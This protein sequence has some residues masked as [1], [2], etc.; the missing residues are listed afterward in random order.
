MEEKT[1]RS[2]IKALYI[3]YNGVLEPL[4]HSQGIPYLK[5]LVTNGIKFTLLSFEKKKHMRR[6]KRI[7]EINSELSR[8]NIDWQRLRYH[9]WPS[10]FA[11]LWD[12]ILGI[13]KS[14]YLILR[15]KIIIVHARGTIPAAIG[16]V[17]AKIFRI[18][19]IFDMRGLLAEEYVDGGNWCRRGH[20]YYLVNALEKKFLFY[21]DAIVVLTDRIKEEIQKSSFISW[22]EVPNIKVIPCCVDLNKFICA[23]KKSE[24]VEKFRLK[25]K[26]VFLYIGSLGTWYLL[27]EMVDFFKTAMEIIPHAHFLIITHS[28]KDIVMKVI[29]SKD[30]N[31][32]AFSITEV[33]PREMADF[34]TLGDVGVIFIKSAFSKLAS[35][36][37]KLGEFLACGLP[38][39]IN[40]GIGDTEELVRQNR[41]GVVLN[42]FSKNSYTNAIKDLLDLLKERDK[43]RQRCRRAAEEFLSLKEGAKKYR[44]IY[45]NLK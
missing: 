14:S 19:F 4:M 41:V 2:K 7:S 17:V 15:K 45:E 39:V 1:L 23:N 28:Q 13:I 9:K 10:L 12:I 25:G 5:E 33:D 24:L 35:S 30:L 26:F 3:S 42:N 18:K 40:S 27:E 43:I 16:F 44:E 38:V 29:L 11:T 8:A 32:K 20:K 36:P 37:T 31:R 6:K 21:S 22:K 34:V